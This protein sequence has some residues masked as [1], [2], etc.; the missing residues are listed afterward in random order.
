[1]LRC[2]MMTLRRGEKR[3]L[4]RVIKRERRRLSCV[5]FVNW[6][7]KIDGR[8][9]RLREISI[10]GAGVIFWSSMISVIFGCSSSRE[11]ERSNLVHLCVG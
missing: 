1:M 4:W 7:G 8:S 9:R 2:C 11:E 3:G 10:W 5:S 6:V